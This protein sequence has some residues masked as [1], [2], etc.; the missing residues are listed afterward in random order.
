MNRK[1]PQFQVPGW[2]AAHVAEV[3]AW[4]AVKGE[5]VRCRVGSCGRTVHSLALCSH[6]YDLFRPRA[7]R[8]GQS[9]AEWLPGHALEVVGAPAV[10]APEALCWVAACGRTAHR[11]GLCKA[12]HRLAS[13]RFREKRGQGR[14][15]DEETTT[16]A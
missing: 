9:L 3:R 13:Y 16:N 6:H 14:A 7:H 5:P 10:V 8:Q 15:S 12:H 1:V 2:L 4:P 11:N